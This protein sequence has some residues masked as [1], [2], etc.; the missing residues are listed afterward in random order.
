MSQNR[1]PEQESNQE[2]SALVLERVTYLR[3]QLAHHLYRYHVLDA[4]G[5]SRC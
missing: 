1:K 5:N 2:P 4:P 3:E